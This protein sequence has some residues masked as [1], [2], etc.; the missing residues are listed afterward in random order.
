MRTRTAAHERVL[1]S[2]GVLYSNI[3]AAPGRFLETLDFLE[4]KE[5]KDPDPAT[6]GHVR[7]LTVWHFHSRQPSAVCSALNF[8]PCGLITHWLRGVQ[9]SCEV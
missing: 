8:Q 2:P 6:G 7:V 9:N 4:K 1:K 5:G 3:E